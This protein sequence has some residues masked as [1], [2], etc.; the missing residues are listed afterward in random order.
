M[1]SH[2]ERVLGAILN[3]KHPR[4]DLL[5]QA[6][7]RLTAEHFHNE[8]ERNIFKFLVRYYDMTGSV[9]PYEQFVQAL[10]SANLDGTK[11]LAYSRAFESMANA[12]VS[13]A[14]YKWSLNE[15]V[16]EQAKRNTGVALTEAMEI[17]ERG[18]TDA[19]GNTYQGHEDA[20]AFLSG[21]IAEI[22][23]LGVVES[24]PEGNVFLDY[25]DIW[26][27]YARRKNGEVKPGVKWGIRAIDERTGGVFP[28]ELDLVCAYANLGKS[29][30]VTQMAWDVAVE[31][32]LN[33]F[34]ATT[35]TNRDTVTRRFLARHSMLPQFDHP[36]DSS[37]LKRGTLSAADEKV[38]A[39]VLEDWRYNS[40]YGTL[41]VVQVPAQSRLSY[42]ENRLIEYG[43]EIELSLCIIDYLT[44]FSADTKRQNEREEFNEILRRTKGIAQGFY[45]GDGI[46]IISPWQITRTAYDNAMRNG[47]YTKASLS[48]TSEAEK[49]ADQIMALI[50]EEDDNRQMSLQFLKVRDDEFPPIT[51]VQI[52]FRHTFI[53]AQ[54][55]T[56]SLMGSA[57]SSDLMSWLQ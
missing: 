9:M 15:L 52:N 3:V 21:K 48:D 5:G 54:S 31:Q 28:G 20:R 35:E 18:Y 23:R 57:Q 12:G 42:V 38:L 36:I 10:E 24:A 53:G 17:L 41:N 19:K 44:L 8:T 45:D 6:I 7:M 50:R 33:V 32:K 43:R 1:A 11:I 25:N 29:Q 26:N 30:V 56:A 37:D 40:E 14:D 51:P 39:D 55:G 34:F 2:A 46:P 13:E 49:S 16:Q 22:E 4:R 27:E 47:R